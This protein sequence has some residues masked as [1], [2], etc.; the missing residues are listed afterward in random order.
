MK[1]IKLQNQGLMD[2]RLLSL[3]GGTTKSKDEFK[4]GQWGSGLKYSL[5]YL[6][7][8]NIAFRIFIGKD[9]VIIDT[10]S[11]TIRDEVFEILRVNGEKTSI[12]TH[13]GGNA[14]EPWTI[15]RELW[16]NCLDEGG[17]LRELTSDIAGEEDKTTFYIQAIP[18]FMNVWENWL[19]Y[20]V[21]DVD[22]MWE[23]HSFKVYSGGEHLRLYKQGV[24]IYQDEKKKSL[25]CYDIRDAEINELREYKGSVSWAMVRCLA[26]AGENVIA[27]FLENITDA[28]YEANMDYD[29]YTNFSTDWRKVIGNAKIIHQKAIDTMIER[30][31]EF[32]SATCI[33][34]PENVYKFLTK[35]FAGVGALRMADKVN[36]FY[37]IFDTHLE[38]KIKQALVIL[39][40]CGYYMSP[41]LKFVYGIF[42]DKNIWAKIHMD[43][44]EVMI[45]EGVKNRSLREICSTLIEENEHFNTGFSDCSRPFQSHFINLY[46][47]T[48]L[49]KNSIE[50]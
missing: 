41:E 24:L 30:G 11:E 10:V 14:W 42:G 36:E 26:G 22:P 2:I 8:N 23:N 49:E 43:T 7:K 45:S 12:T 4:I 50:L 44:K 6:L 21:H 40:A 32:D 39:E 31:V 34:V 9:E 15:I 17:Y 35:E 16:C 1:Y 5:A 3:M 33:V 47:K 37:E 27:Y 18:D 28:Y 19:N 38:S 20:F 48:L 29:W 13:M 46:T 25:F